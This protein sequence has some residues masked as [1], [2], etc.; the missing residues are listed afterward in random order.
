MKINLPNQITLGRLGL[1]II[2]F[3]MLSLYSQ[4]DYTRQWWMLDVAFVL[5]I[6]AALTDILDGYLARKHNLV[7]PLGRILDPLVDKV[8]VCGAFILFTGP[9][10]VDATGRNVTE[11]K[12]WMVV[13]IVGRELLVTGIRG[14]NESIGREFPA[15]IHGKIKMWVQ[16]IAA[17]TVLLVIAH[18][19]TWFAQPVAHWFKLVAV[20]ATVIVTALSTIHY[21][22]RSR[23]I[24]EESAAT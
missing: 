9:G 8:L 10:F 18:E 23:H 19:G 5:F 22:V 13:I 15:S 7:T 1:A 6:V 2:F 11:V 4:Q 17:P 12:A 24:F 14:F 16:S 20:W 3:T 21:L